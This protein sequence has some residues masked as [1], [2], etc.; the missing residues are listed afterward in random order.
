MRL[1][2]K[3]NDKVV[4]LVKICYLLHYDYKGA[5][6]EI[7][8]G[9]FSLKVKIFGIRFRDDRQKNQNSLIELGITLINEW[10]SL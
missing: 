10:R 3:C 7:L 1:P 5:S 6:R 4:L 2:R 8:R 9:F